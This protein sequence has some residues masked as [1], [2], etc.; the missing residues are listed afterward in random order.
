M[1]ILFTGGGTGGHIYPI[2]AV[3]EELQI[4]ASKKNIPLKMYY[5]GAP[6]KYKNLLN[7]NG[8]YVSKIF[9]A[10]LRR[11]FDIG[12]FIDI[13]FFFFSIPQALWKIFW[14]M[15]DV[16]FSKGGPGSL[17]VVLACRFYNIPIIVHESDSIPGLANKLAFYFADR[18]GV[19]F[20]SVIENIIQQQK[21]KKKVEIIQEKIA[22]V[23]NP[24]RQSLIGG[25][26]IDKETAK[27]VLGFNP[28]MSLI[29]ILG[30]SQGSAQLNDFMLNISGELVKD[31]QIFHQT[32]IEN[33]QEV[34]NELNNVLKKYGEEEKMRYKL[35]PYFENNM[36]DAYSA[37]DVVIS[38]A[39]SGSIFEIAAFGKPSILIPL[40]E[41]IVGLHQI[42]NAYEYSKSGAAIVIEQNNL[43][44]N[45]FIAQLM[46][47]IK[48][49]ELLKTMSEA[50]K[51]F[52]KPEASKMIANE[53]LRLAE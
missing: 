40:S 26:I 37:V 53:I 38:R 11:Y 14:L 16:L 31:I 52:S 18:I 3:A 21:N 4:L 5:L 29:L 48:N 47:I 51:S 43:K 9:S 19:S 17:P 33:F 22:L 39:G 1:R 36:K 15:P 8:I 7:E 28:T 12:N 6:G 27:K 32:G 41:K 50:A 46:K 30:G 35:I 42:K 23:G 20:S 44:P 24:I 49:Q 34:K 25:D 10:K 2:I 13:P 45:I